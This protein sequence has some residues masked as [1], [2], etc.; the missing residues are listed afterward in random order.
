MRWHQILH[1]RCLSL[2]QSQATFDSPSVALGSSSLPLLMFQPFNSRSRNS[3]SQGLSAVL[4]VL[5][6]FP[7][8]AS[9]T[10]PSTW[11]GPDKGTTPSVHAVSGLRASK[12]HCR[13]V[14]IRN[15]NG[16]IFTRTYGLSKRRVPCTT[17][18]QVARKFIS[19]EGEGGP[20]RPLGFKCSFTS[21]GVKC[22]RGYQRVD[23]RFKS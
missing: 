22:K 8:M 17:A 3:W 16:S 7:T 2:D 9:A 12:H 19:F 23:W 15:G 1:S 20:P 5:L 14:V 10:V 21:R 11:R 18:R 4:L 13:D 6:L